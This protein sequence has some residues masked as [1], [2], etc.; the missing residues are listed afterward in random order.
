MKAN[1]GFSFIRIKQM[2]VNLEDFHSF[3]NMFREQEIRVTGSA[4]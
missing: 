2:K 3:A 4:K 1:M